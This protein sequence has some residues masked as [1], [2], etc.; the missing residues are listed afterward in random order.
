MI[1]TLFVISLISFLMMHLA[2]GDPIA[3]YM[4]P[5]KRTM[6]TEDVEA[7][8]HKLGLDRPVQIQYFYWVTNTMQGDWGYSLKSKAPVLEEILSRLP[9]TLL[10]AGSAILITIILAIPI[11]IISAVKRYTFIDYVTTIGAFIGISMPGFWFALILLNIFSNKLGWLPSV[12]MQ[13]LGQ[14]TG[15]MDKVI[16]VLR[17]L[18]LPMIAMSAV[19]MAYWARYQRSSLLEVMNQDYIRTA[20]SKGLRE[21]LVVIRHGFRNALIP[22]VTL[23]GLTFPD[24]VSGSYIIE[25]VFGWPGM[26]RLGVNSLIYRDYPIVMGVTMLSALLVVTG[27]LVAD[28]LYAL[29]DPRIHQA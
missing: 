1:P 15:G 23:L 27:N 17:H 25:T 14:S 19:E 4:N 20:R 5:Q 29:V 13:T 26:G 7:L 16:D 10:L 6:T 24:L 22:M 12:G 3:M 21:R 2:P 28:I 11:G 8:R 9:N 18:I